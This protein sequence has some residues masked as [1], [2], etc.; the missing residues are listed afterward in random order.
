MLFAARPADLDL[1]S[2]E[3]RRM[4]NRGEQVSLTAVHRY[5]CPALASS[6]S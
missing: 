2:A 5:E 6:Q 4:K 1:S 3:R